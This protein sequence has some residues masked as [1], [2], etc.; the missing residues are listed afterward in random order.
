VDRLAEKTGA[1]CNSGPKREGAVVHL[2]WQD[3][4]C[5]LYIDTSGE[6]LSRRGYRLLPGG[7]PMQETLASGVVRACGWDG[8]SNFINPMCGSGTLAIEAALDALNRKPGMLRRNFGFMHLI[9]YDAAGFMVLRERLFSEEHGSLRGA[10]IAADRD[11]SAL[12]AAKANAKAAGVDRCIDFEVCNFEK[13]RVP[14]GSGVV[15]VNPEYGFRMGDATALQ[16]V[17]A[18]I[19]DFFKQRC[20]GYRGFIFSGNFDLVKKVGLKA[21][22]KIP[23]YSGKIE[24]R[25]Y[26]YELYKGRKQQ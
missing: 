9:S 4:K 6:S 25:L 13:T 7:A 15:V 8:K 17:Y 10:V 19:G 20:S 3:E 11:P 18:K 5:T 26:E 24:C 22:R 14:E 12:A 21:G 16:A 2:Y 1:R 23:F